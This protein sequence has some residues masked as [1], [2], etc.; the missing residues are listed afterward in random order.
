MSIPEGPEQEKGAKVANNLLHV[1]SYGGSG[2]TPSMECKVGWTVHNMS[3]Y[4]EDPGLNPGWIS[5]SFFFHHVVLFWSYFD[6][7]MS[8]KKDTRL[9]LC[10]HTF[11]SGGMRLASPHRYRSFYLSFTCLL[12]SLVPRLSPLIWE[13]E[14]RAICSMCLTVLCLLSCNSRRHHSP[15]GKEERDEERS[16]TR[17]EKKE[18]R[19]TRSKSRTPK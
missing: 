2:D 12:C 11:Q 5:M 8:H 15:S 13:P 1:S 18:E 9:S 7:V 6:Y 14:R 19:E 16:S 4:W 3:F 10:I 17:K